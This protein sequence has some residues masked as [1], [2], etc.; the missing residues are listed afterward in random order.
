MFPLSSIG[1]PTST[2]LSRVLFITGDI[3]TQQ[4]RLSYVDVF[5]LCV[6]YYNGELLANYAEEEEGILVVLA[7]EGPTDTYR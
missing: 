5:V 1:S 2:C 3:P 4:H 6:I 7:T